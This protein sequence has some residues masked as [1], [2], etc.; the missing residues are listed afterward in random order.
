MTLFLFNYVCMIWLMMFRIWR[1]FKHV[2]F[3][4]HNVCTT[5]ILKCIYFI[6]FKWLIIKIKNISTFLF[7][8]HVKDNV[9]N[10]FAIF[11]LLLFIH[12]L[13]YL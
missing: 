8:L 5:F 2:W 9:F 11:I 4:I 3:T 10:S 7:E 12:I 1:Y 6:I 13:I